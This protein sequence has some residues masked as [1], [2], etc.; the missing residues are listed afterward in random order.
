MGKGKSTCAAW[1]CTKTGAQTKT[2]FYNKKNDNIKK[3]KMMFSKGAKARTLHKLK[4][5]KSSS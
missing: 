3:E 1:K 2:I 5:V 4:E